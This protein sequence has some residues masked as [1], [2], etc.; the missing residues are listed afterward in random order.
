MSLTLRALP[1]RVVL[2][3]P[4]PVEQRNGLYIPQTSQQ[5]PEFG[6]V[7]DVGEPLNE[8]QA[9]IAKWLWECKEKNIPLPV[10]YGAGTSYWFGK[11]NALTSDEWA[12][13]RDFRVFT[14]TEP[15]AMLVEAEEELSLGYS[16]AG[17]EEAAG[18]PV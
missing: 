2:R 13:L 10:S 3:F 17:D 14:I 7:M 9:T 18:I 15:A 16:V 8:E 12:W 11:E 6:E 5:R 4:K 1:G